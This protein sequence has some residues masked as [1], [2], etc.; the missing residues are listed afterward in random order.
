MGDLACVKSN[1]FLSFSDRESNFDS[2]Q[3][4]RH[5]LPTQKDVDLFNSHG[6]FISKKVIP[7]IVIDRMYTASEELYNGIK[8]AEL[9]YQGCSNWQN[10]DAVSVRNNEYI[11]LQKKAFRQLSLMPI[12]GAI[13]AKLM[14]TDTVR[15]FQDQLITKEI[16]DDKH[17]GNSKIGW[18]T[19]RSYHSNC[20]SHKLLT[21]WIPLHDI[22][23]D[24]GPLVVIDRS[25][26]WSKTE[27]MRGFNHDNHD[28]LEQEFIQQK[29]EIQKIPII[30]KKGQISFHSSS[31]VHCSYANHSDTQRRV[32][33][34]NLQDGENRYQTFWNNGKQ[35]H[36]YLDPLCRKQTNGLPD[37]TDSDVFPIVWTKNKK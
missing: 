15:Y 14:D 13:A 32:I 37:Y 25:H 34:I 2:T 33:A 29:R 35:I 23:E 18:H 4:D 1:S 17:Q 9:P 12:I 31:L 26:K 22:T 11:S 20:T 7:D 8:D 10:G 21:V 30:L 6:W 28:Q 24:C 27:H 3:I 19:D 36:H 5:L 16:S